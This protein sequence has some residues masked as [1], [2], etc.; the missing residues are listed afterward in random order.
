MKKLLGGL[1]ISALLAAPAMAADLP[2]RVAARPAPPPIAY[3]MYNWSGFYFGGHAGYGWGDAEFTVAP[4]SLT[5]DADG[6]VGGGHVGINWQ[7]D[8]LVLGIEGSV[9]FFNNDDSGACTFGTTAITACSHEV[10]HFWRAGG[11]LG[12]ATGASGNWLVYGMGGFARA[13]FE[14]ALTIG[15]VTL[16]NTEHHH[17]WYG[18]GGVE[19]G[20]TPN[21]IIGVEGYFASLGNETYGTGLYTRNIDL[22]F[23]V[24]QARASYK[25]NWG[26]SPVVAR[27]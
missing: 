5:R 6:F 24:V 10:K 17:G 3:P 2:A 22:D 19:Y 21:F 13:Q 16:S 9:S 20:V 12:F 8:R 7:W 15:G 27:Y 11:R 1:A 4:N 25:F 23:A 18:G 14:T 26:S